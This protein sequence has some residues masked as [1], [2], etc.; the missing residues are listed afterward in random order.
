MNSREYDL[1]GLPT[2][3]IASVLTR[4]IYEF[5][6]LAVQKLD[7]SVD[8]V[9]IVT[10][11]S[12]ESTRPIVEEAYLTQVFG[13][14][15]SALPIIERPPVKLK[16][17]AGSLGMNRETCRRR[18]IRLVERGFLVKRGGGYIFPEQIED[19]DFTEDMRRNLTVKFLELRKYIARAEISR[20][21]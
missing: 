4:G 3:Y 18:L 7:L 17:I 11:V 1:D 15:G 19:N 13:Y 9:A 21:L 5:L 2:R 12:A 20:E 16:F 6:V 8:E 10:L 14:E